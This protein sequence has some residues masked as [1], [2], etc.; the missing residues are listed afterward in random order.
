MIKKL[1]KYLLKTLLFV[2]GFV[3]LYG[4][5]CLLLPLISIS[6]EKTAEP[7]TITIYLLSNGMHTDLL[8]PTENEYINWATKVSSDDTKGKMR[9]DWLA[10]GWGDKGFYLNTP[11]WADLNFSTAVKAAFWMS[12]SAMH[13]TY[14][15]GSEGYEKVAQLSLTPTQYKRLI[16]YIDQQFD[17]DAQGK[18][19]PIPTNAVYGILMLFTKP[20][21][22]TTFSIPATLGQTMGFVLPD[23]NTPS[24]QPPIQEYLGIININF[25]K[26]KFK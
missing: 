9:G 4:A 7:K 19:I 15:G 14:L 2:V 24:G 16:G 25:L 5:L 8:L 1:F 23:K 6:A 10:F 12:D 21:V 11:T 20:K 26:W 3:V 13:T 22:L 18:Y 17:K